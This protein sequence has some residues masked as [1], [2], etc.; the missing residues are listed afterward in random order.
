MIHDQITNADTFPK[1]WV[2]CVVVIL[3]PRPRKQWECRCGSTKCFITSTT[4]EVCYNCYKPGV[5]MDTSGFSNTI[6]MATY[7]RLTDKLVRVIL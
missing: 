7:K 4:T 6:Q 1:E 3:S 5:E 2:G